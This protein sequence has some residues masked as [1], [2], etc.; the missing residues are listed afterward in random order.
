MIRL[1]RAILRAL[2]TKCYLRIDGCVV[3]FGLKDGKL[4]HAEIIAANC[5]EVVLEALNLPESIK[6]Q[7][8][9]DTDSKE[10]RLIDCAPSILR[11]ICADLCCWVCSRGKDRKSVV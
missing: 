1:Q 6:E 8:P 4:F 3:Q 11:N 10:K 7:P 9:G 2:E 5:L